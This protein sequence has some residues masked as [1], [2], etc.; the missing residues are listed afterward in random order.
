MDPE[1]WRDRWQKKEIGFH[2]AEVHG[3]LQRHWGRLGLAS[4]ADVL[5]PLCG[6]SLDIV[7]LADQGHRV[8]GVELSEL[9]VNEFF[10]E[11]GLT[12]Q[13]ETAATLTVKRAGPYELWCGDF[14]ALPPEA[15]AHVAGVYDRAALVALPPDMRARYAERLIEILPLAAQMLVITFD[16][17]QDKVSGP[18]FAVPRDEVR[19]L[20]DGAFSVDEISARTGPSRIPRF[21]EAGVTAVEECAFILRR[22]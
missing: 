20:F 17:D 18:P 13:V 21:A 2:Q 3:D 14:F 22:R 11:R 8:I 7:W 6:K 9:A 5:V 16:Y 4:S 15:T 1:F 10:E 12:P 19:R